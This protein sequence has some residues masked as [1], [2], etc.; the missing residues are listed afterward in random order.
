[1]NNVGNI[2]NKVVNDPDI[3]TLLNENEIEYILERLSLFLNKKK[4]ILN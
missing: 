3:V 1:M 2:I 4:H